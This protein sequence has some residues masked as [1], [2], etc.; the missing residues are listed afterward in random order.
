MKQ[1]AELKVELVTNDRCQD[2]VT[3][4]ID[5][6]FRFGALPDSSATARKIMQRSRVLVAS[7][8]YL[9]ERGTPTTPS[10]LAHHSVIIGPA[11]SSPTFSLRKDGPRLL[12][13]R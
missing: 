1:H 9:R 10:D 12:R 7:P 13:A 4:G 5:V 11:H 6:A 8:D 3:E 2:L